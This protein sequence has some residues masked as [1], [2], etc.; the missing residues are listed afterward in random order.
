MHYAGIRKQRM[1]RISMPAQMRIAHH[2]FV[3]LGVWLEWALQL[4]R[5]CIPQ[6]GIMYY[7]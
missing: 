6:H 4:I 2:D 3:A 5:S 1:R 7:L